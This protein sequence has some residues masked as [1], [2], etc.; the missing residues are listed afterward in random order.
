MEVEMIIYVNGQVFDFEEDKSKS[1]LHFLVENNL[2]QVAFAEAIGVKQ[3]QVSEWLKG[4]AK[5][6]YDTLKSMA[7]A[8]NVSAD[9][10]LGIKEY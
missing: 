2:T 10:F 5:P 8:F 6:G 4:K 3:S 1:L 9:Y 7:L